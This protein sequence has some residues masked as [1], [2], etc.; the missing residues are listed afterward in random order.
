M[1]LPP[2]FFVPV[3]VF[4][5]ANRIALLCDTSL[6]PSLNLPLHMNKIKGK[7]FNQCFVFN[8][9]AVLTFI[10]TC[11][12]LCSESSSHL[13]NDSLDE[14]KKDLTSAVLNRD[15]TK[16][17]ATALLM[18][19]GDQSSVKSVDEQ[20]TIK[21][22]STL[23]TES[24]VQASEFSK[25]VEQ[26]DW[27]GIMNLAAQYEGASDLDSNS[28]T[29]LST[30]DDLSATCTVQTTSSNDAFDFS[31]MDVRSQVEHLGQVAPEEVGKCPLFRATS[32]ASLFGFNTI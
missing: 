16:I 13:S 18:T 24:L 31:Q 5:G 25:L 8:C 20:S 32:Q 17:K 19:K 14:I 28:D 22:G 4:W 9:A 6:D 29:K 30:S 26:G 1:W 27:Q 3:Q 7:S 12:H 15:W 11:L 23:G 10:Y 21:S 2:C